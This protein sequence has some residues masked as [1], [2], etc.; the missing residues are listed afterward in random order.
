MRS[1]LAIAVLVLGVAAPQE[2]PTINVG[3]IVPNKPGAV[4]PITPGIEVSVYGQ[5]LGPKTGC[6][7]GTG[8][9]TDGKQLCGTAPASLLYVGAA[10][11]P[12]NTVQTYPPRETCPSWLPG[13][14]A[15][16]ELWLCGF[17]LPRVQQT[18]GRG[19]RGHAD[20]W[21]VWGANAGHNGSDAR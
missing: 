2:T 12:S 18:L 13:K 16:A 14:D 6:T 5:H 1:V 15:Q 10:D 19:I 11:Q 17:A 21:L 7:A 4:G 20:G 3:G 8:G 9:W